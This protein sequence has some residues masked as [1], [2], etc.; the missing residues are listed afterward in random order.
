M[1]EKRIAWSFFN[2]HESHEFHEFYKR[3]GLREDKKIGYAELKV[4]FALLKIPKCVLHLFNV[5]V[6]R[7]MR[8]SHD[9]FCILDRYR[10]GRGHYVL[11]TSPAQCG[12]CRWCGG[13]D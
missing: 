2:E 7:F 13:P 9:T 1:V 3:G 11:F 4:G 8:S 5:I 10:R 12:S 6:A